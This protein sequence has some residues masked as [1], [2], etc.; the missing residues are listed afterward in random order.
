VRACNFRQPNTP[1][2]RSIHGAIQ[3]GS[4]AP[5]N[6]LRFG[7]Y[8]RPTA[9]P[10][11]WKLFFMNQPSPLPP[12]IEH[13]PD[14]PPR[15]MSKSPWLLVSII[16]ALM[17]TWLWYNNEIQ[18][19]QVGVGF[20]TGMMLMAWAIEITDNKVPASWRRQ[21]PRSR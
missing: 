8:I 17:W 7:R 19:L 6:Q 18:W 13:D 14:E 5:P 2:N 9:F 20:Y 15:D 3:A 12:T 10:L 21:P 16:C 1:V 11:Y 4:K